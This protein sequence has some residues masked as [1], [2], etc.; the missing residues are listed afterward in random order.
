MSDGSVD[1]ATQMT[2]RS[3]LTGATSRSPPC[4]P[5]CVFAPCAPLCAHCASRVGHVDNYRRRGGCA[6]AIL[7]IHCDDGAR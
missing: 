5:L 2:G 7:S 6:N 3:I 4:L 1:P